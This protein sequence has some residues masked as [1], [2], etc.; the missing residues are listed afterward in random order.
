MNHVIGKYRKQ[1][2]II[3]LEELV[4]ADS[5]V[6]QIDEIVNLTDTS[7]FEKSEVKHTGRPPYNPKDMLKLYIYGMDNGIVSS[8][9]LERECK[10]NIEVKWLINGLAPESSTICAFRQENAENLIKFFNEFSRKLAKDGYIDGKIVAIDGTKIRA[11]NSKRNN[12]SASKLDRHIE[13]IEEKVAEYLNEVDKNDKI[14]A[15]EERKEKYK[16][17]K[18]RI[19]NGEVTEVS[20]TDADSR[21]MKQGNNGVDV[22]YNVQ[23]AIDSKNKLIVGVMVMNEA[24]DQGQLSKLA[25]AVKSNL[26]LEKMIVPADKGY[27]DTEDLKECHENGITTIV[28]IPEG[29]CPKGI[30]SKEEFQYNKENDYYICPNGCILNFAY[31]CERGF[32]R[33]RNYKACK[34][35]KLKKLCTKSNRREI[36]RHK[37]AEHAERNDRAF[38]ENQD[39]YKLRQLLCEHPFGTVKRTMGIRQFLTRGLRNVNA[40]AAL[41]FL[42]YNLKR[43][44]NIH[45]NDNQK[46]E[47]ACALSVFLVIVYVLER[48]VNLRRKFKKYLKFMP[49]PAV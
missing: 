29:K 40:E 35:C 47:Q 9:K 21:L 19:E 23:A 11:N 32:L 38:K 49:F 16:L 25:K 7:Y 22:S 36:A 14:E 15:L 17:F 13:Y 24:N 46:D 18:K 45:K 12:F 28:A 41:I 30:Y 44:R 31:E 33:Y 37:Y 20:T 4:E 3:S 48:F 27:H 10:R 6:R 42:T 1:V 2:E 34:S 8:R 43:L 26:M 5:A 39:I